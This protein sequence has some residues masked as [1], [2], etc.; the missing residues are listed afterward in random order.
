M[1]TIYTK[2]ALSN[3][4]KL[5]KQIAKQISDKIKFFAKQ[6]N[7]LMFAKKLKNLKLEIYRFRVG[8]YRIIFEIDK[9]GKIKILLILAV[10][11]R[12]DAYK[13]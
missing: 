9:K 7:P 10:K 3:L 1:K 5:E 12:K 2:K 13:N 6:D 11:H 4:S 8:N